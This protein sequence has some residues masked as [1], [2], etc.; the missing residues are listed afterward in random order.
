MSIK[1]PDATPGIVQKYA[2]ADE[3]ALLAKL[4]YN[5]LLD[6]F[7]GVTCYSL[8]NHKLRGFALYF[9]QPRANDYP[10]DSKSRGILSCKYRETPS[11]SRQ[12]TGRTASR[13]IRNN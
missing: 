6:I 8:Q 5:R 12:S 7:T 9:L 1:I 2:L 10:A 4:R 13:S 3:Q 11:S